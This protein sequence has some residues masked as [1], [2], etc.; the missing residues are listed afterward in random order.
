MKYIIFINNQAAR[1]LLQPLCSEIGA[2]AMK[3]VLIV[4]SEAT[5]AQLREVPGVTHVELD[6]QGHVHEVVD[7]QSPPGWGLP[8]ISNSGGSYQNQQ[9][10]SGVD[11]YIIDTGIRDTHVDLQGRVETL[12]SFDGAPYSLTGYAPHHG[13]AVAGCAAGTLYGTAKAASII[14]LRIDF[15]TVSI[16]KAVDM[17]LKHHIAKPRNRQSVV[18]FSGGSPSAMVGEIFAKLVHWG[19]PVIAS[20]GNESAQEPGYPARSIYVE[21]VGA[22]N[23]QEGP[24]WFTNR[25]ADVYGP[26]QG[27]TTSAVFSD[28]GTSV[29]N[30]TS[31]SCPYYSGIMACLLSGSDKFNTFHQVS[32]FLHNTKLQF[33]DTARIPTFTNYGLQVRT[34]NCRGL[35]GIY[36]AN[37]SNG[38]SDADIAAF[39]TANYSAP[40]VIADAAREYNV[41][42]AR[43]SQALNISPEEINAYFSNENVHPWWFVDGVPV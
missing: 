32:D 7:Q 37:P 25:K 42:L 34:F 29:V 3:D 19:I 40:Q 8:W 36:Y 15:S 11:I 16:I 43:F 12:W 23:E 14:N 6:S 13:T 10:G 9:D 21:A 41:D 38:F 28:T 22:I 5:E 35:S 33:C 17:V 27:V 31:F 2:G 26:G 39:C 1:E 30:G 24:A 4:T 18:N 20:S